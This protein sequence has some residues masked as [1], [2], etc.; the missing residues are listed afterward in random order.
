MI[1]TMSLFTST[2]ALGVTPEEINCPIGCLAVP[3]LE[4]SLYD[5]CYLTQNLL[6]LQN[7]YVYLVSL[8]GQMFSQYNAQ[9]LVREDIVGLKDVISTRMT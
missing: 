8:M 1:K 2:E 6:H 7:L 4:L 5:K 9:D 3:G